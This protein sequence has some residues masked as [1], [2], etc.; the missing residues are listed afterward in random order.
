[1]KIFS[2]TIL[3]FISFQVCGQDIIEKKKRK[4]LSDEERKYTYAGQTLEK[5]DIK[6][7]IYNS[8]DSIAIKY[9]SDHKTLTLIGG[10]SNVGG[11]VLLFVVLLEG[12]EETIC[13]ITLGTAGPH[14]FQQSK[15]NDALAATA[16]LLIG[17]GVIMEIVGSSKLKMSINRFNSLKQSSLKV[18][19]NRNGIGLIYNF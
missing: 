10:I 12:R 4:F 11:A 16:L 1:M 8:R 5:K 6:K 3:L 17:G 15:N 14:C 18:D 7:L 13:T 9:Y 2:I 19:I